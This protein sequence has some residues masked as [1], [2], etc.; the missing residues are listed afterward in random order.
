M[1]NLLDV[2]DR[3]NIQIEL[4]NYITSQ[5]GN[6]DAREIMTVIDDMANHIFDYDMDEIPEDTLLRARAVMCKEKEQELKVLD[7]PYSEINNV[8]MRVE[9]L[10]YITEEF[11]GMLKL[12]KGILLLSN[13]IPFMVIER[14][15]ISR[16]N[17]T[18]LAYIVMMHELGKFEYTW[19]MN[20][21]P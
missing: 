8:G 1:L 2:I 3:Q 11:E 12:D 9:L 13:R 4:S 20:P 5:M 7:Y 14:Y 17:Y 21:N 18:K 16:S 6:M 10:E 15:G 19:R